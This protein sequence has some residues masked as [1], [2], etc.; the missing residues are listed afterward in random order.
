M[1][2]R[3][4]RNY[5]NRKKGGG[6]FFP[7]AMSEEKTK[8][9]I[10]RA[11]WPDIARQVDAACSALPPPR[12]G[13]PPSEV[14]RRYLADRGLP[15]SLLASRRRTGDVVQARRDIA[16]ACYCLW[17]PQW[18][19]LGLRERMPRAAAARLSAVLGVRR[20]KLVPTYLAPAMCHYRAYAGY[21]ERMDEFIDFLDGQLTIDN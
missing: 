19:G 5:P 10:L 18:R 20:D 9:G 21:R 13:V 7:F 12:P 15:P 8:I 6:V 2:P 14:A 11:R 1:P 4:Y 17:R 3:G 16:L